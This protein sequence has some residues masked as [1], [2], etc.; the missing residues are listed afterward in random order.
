MVTNGVPATVSAV[1]LT[2]E[3][4]ARPESESNVQSANCCAASTCKPAARTTPALNNHFISIVQSCLTSHPGPAH[5]TS[6]TF[7]RKKWDPSGK[8]GTEQLLVEGVA[9]MSL[10][11]IWNDSASDRLVLCSTS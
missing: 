9:L 10:S 5:G 2:V 1:A 3:P 4:F 8:T 7:T 11:K 6:L